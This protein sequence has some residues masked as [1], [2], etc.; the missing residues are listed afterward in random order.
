MAKKEYGQI[1]AVSTGYKTPVLDDYDLNVSRVVLSIVDS[2]GDTAFGY[3]DSSVDFG[4]STTYHDSTMTSTIV[5]YKNVGGVKT[6]VFEAT[7]T[8]MDVGEFTFN[9]TTLAS[10]TS[11][12]FTVY[13][14]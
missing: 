1:T 3:H 10:S 12:K 9:V 8:N 5:H 13:E 6:K 2:N 14:D 4:G 7:V 11:V